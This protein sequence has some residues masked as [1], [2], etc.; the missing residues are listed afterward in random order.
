MAQSTAYYMIT[1]LLGFLVA[2]CFAALLFI[3]GAYK[4]LLTKGQHLYARVI[5][6]D[7]DTFFWSVVSPEEGAAWV[8]AGSPRTPDGQPDMAAVASEEIIQRWHREVPDLPSD[9]LRWFNRHGRLA[10]S[11]PPNQYMVKSMRSDFP[12]WLSQPRSPLKRCKS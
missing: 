6:R 8:Q 9:F 4:E 11:P 10:G 7:P 2:W 12:E 3:D 5:G 1:F